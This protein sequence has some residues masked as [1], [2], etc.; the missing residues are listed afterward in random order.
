MT[1]LFPMTNCSS[2]FEDSLI[3]YIEGEYIYTSSVAGGKLAQLAVNRG[4][5][6]HV[7]D[8]L[9]QLD[10]QPEEDIRDASKAALLETEAQ[11][12]FS[13]L[14][15]ER[16][17]RLFA[18]RTIDKSAVDQAEADYKT[19]K[20][21][22]I[23]AKEQLAQAEWTL[24]QKKVYAPIDSK[25]FDVYFRVGEYVQPN[26][27][28]L[29]LLAPQ[30]IKVLFYIPE[31]A[32]RKIRIGQLVRVGCDGCEEE[33]SATISYISP[34]AEYTPPVIYS[35]DT[36][37]KLVYLVRADLPIDIAK[38]FHPGQPLDITINE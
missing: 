1:T 27:P 6:V 30:N 29:A 24:A 25:V 9:F 10:P 31:T 12:T 17:K 16:Q 23:A 15:Y 18:Q 26:Q 28:V 20:E 32:L 22:V 35:K 5:T 19:K 37:Y 2:E 13:A 36:R 21:E 8:L 38:D 34:E 7:G 4:Q 33:V 11:L 14:Q 3:G